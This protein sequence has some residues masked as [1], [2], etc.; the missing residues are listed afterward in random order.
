MT[1]GQIF[2]SDP[3]GL[4]A[5]ND[6]PEVIDLDTL[7]LFLPDFYAL[8]TAGITKITFSPDATIT[9]NP[10]VFGR[11]DYTLNS[12]EE[13]TITTMPPVTADGFESVEAKALV[14]FQDTI[15]N[16]RRRIALPAPRDLVFERD[17]ETNIK[18]VTS[19][20]GATLAGVFNNLLTGTWNLQF[21][22]GKP[23]YPRVTDKYGKSG[24]IKYLV[25]S[26]SI[27]L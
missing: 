10:H 27:N 2:Y 11:R 13:R 19:G 1:L 25:K 23:I 24:S 8:T 15:T 9:Y 4:E 26:C 18:Q 7:E 5:H 21:V 20:I 17:P 22:S 6:I 14:C 3:D 12:P 16:K